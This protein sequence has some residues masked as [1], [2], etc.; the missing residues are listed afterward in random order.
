MSVAKAGQRAATDSPIVGL[1]TSAGG[2]A[3]W[4]RLCNR[5]H[6][7]FVNSVIISYLLESFFGTDT[8]KE[9]MKFRVV[10]ADDHKPFREALRNLLER[11]PGIEIIGEAGDGTEMLD[12]VR[13]G[14]PDVVVLDMRM[15]GMNGIDTVRQLAATHPSAKLIVVTA[16]S[17]STFA[18][19]TLGA[20][21]SG[22]VTK[23]DAEELPRAIHAVVRGST[24]LSAEVAAT[25]VD[26]V[27]P[28]QTSRLPSHEHTDPAGATLR[29]SPA[30]S[31][32]LK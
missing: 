31:Y 14:Q 13:S 1:G 21:A 6:F 26:R 22:Y 23:A 29:A 16:T 25:A 7:L 2:L 8:G 27:V 9:N 32:Q 18:A 11:D 15:P 12:L 3:R 28:A 20:G 4:Q 5:P 24:Y 17:E 19:E 30:G 10:L